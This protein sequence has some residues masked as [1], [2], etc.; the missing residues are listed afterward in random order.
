MSRKKS[1]FFLI[2]VDVSLFKNGFHF[3]ETA[4][5]GLVIK[6]IDKA[7]P[8]RIAFRLGGFAYFIDEIDDLDDENGMLSK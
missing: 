6:I 7:S 8:R 1:K 4:V 3:P 5:K 2:R